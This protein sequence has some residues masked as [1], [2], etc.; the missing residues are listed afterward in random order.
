MNKPVYLKLSILGLSK[1]LMHVFWCD[2]V[3]PKY[4]EKAKL[5]YLDTES[6]IVYIKTGDIYKD[7]AEDVEEDVNT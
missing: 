7:V 5:C 2:C 3:K 4:N 1:T 6:F